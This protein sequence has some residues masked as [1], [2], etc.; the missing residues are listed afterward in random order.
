MA[1]RASVCAQCGEKLGFF[2]KKNELFG[3]MVCDHCY[4]YYL[5]LKNTI[6]FPED[7]YY[8]QL[9]LDYS[10][11]NAERFHLPDGKENRKR[12]LLMD[13]S[14]GLIQISSKV[15]LNVNDLSEVKLSLSRI[16][17]KE[18]AEFS[19]KVAIPG[20][21]AEYEFHVSWYPDMKYYNDFINNFSRMY[22]KRQKRSD[23]QG[24]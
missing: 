2:S 6:S 14:A 5:R 7:P 4:S 13:V 9:C 3:Q 1:G 12:E 15:T 22:V 18:L 21:Y 20:A 10:L 8:Y 11:K 19:G 17:D 23:A 16:T 24:D